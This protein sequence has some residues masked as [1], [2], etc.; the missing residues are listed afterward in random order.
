MSTISY[1]RIVA[2]SVIFLAL[3]A[4][5]VLVPKVSQDPIFLGRYS[6]RA[7]LAIVGVALA[8]VV[9]ASA[10]L[11]WPKVSQGL[12]LCRYLPSASWSPS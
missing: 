5:V 3:A 1:S 10:A 7:L 11:K 2:C 12:S 9:V 8:T 4:E 6:A